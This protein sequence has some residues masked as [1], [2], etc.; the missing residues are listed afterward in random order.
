MGRP[1]VVAG[2][3]SRAGGG[4][5]RLHPEP[6][7]GYAPDLNPLDLGV[8]HLLEHV[9]LANVCGADLP[10][11]RRELD[12]AAKRLRRKPHRIRGSVRLAGHQLHFFTPGSV[13]WAA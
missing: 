3:V 8:R 6:L 12:E 7:P 13:G 11:L 9:E 4:A 2:A 5:T 1:A 10:N